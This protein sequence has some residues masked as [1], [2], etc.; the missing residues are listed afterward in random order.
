MTSIGYARV[1]TVQQDYGIQ[2]QALRD[3]GCTIIRGEKISGKSRDGR[4]ELATVLEFLRP[5][6]ELVVQRLDR[7]GRDTRDVLNVVFEI[8]QKGATLRVLNP[9]ISTGGIEGKIMMTVLGLVAE[10]ERNFLRERQAAGIA[11]A[12]VAGAYKGRKPK[13]GAATVKALLAEGLGA[14]EIGKMYGISRQAV[15]LKTKE[16]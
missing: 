7:L 5:G 4:T 11:K 2:E 1:S 16:T 12:K 15:Y 10:M 3:A 13:V 14:T 8:E 9:A 6:D